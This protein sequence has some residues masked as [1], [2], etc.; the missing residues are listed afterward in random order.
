MKQYA[1][2]NGRA[3]RKEYWI[4]TLFNVIIIF[5]LM[6]VMKV[7]T[8]L[9][10]SELSIIGMVLFYGYVLAI[11]I[12]SLAVC[13]R[14][15]HDI[16]KS[17]WY[18]FIGLIP[19]VGGIILFIWFCKDGQAD[20]NE[21]GVNPKETT[22]D[23]DDSTCDTIVLAVVIWMFVSRLF[24]VLITKFIDGY[25]AMEWYKPID[26]LMSFIWAIIPISLAFTVKNK[27]KQ[28]ILFI[29]GGIYLLYSIEQ[30]N[31]WQN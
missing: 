19:L 18:Y 10:S 30:L 13:V 2:F 4:F 3:S 6:S 20:K 25:Y 5:A 24:W 9:E 29:L 17:G 14:R 27:S 21:Y 8:A 31:N 1:D 12:P 15:L 11:I 28:V 26:A 22:S 23:N 16:G 7:G